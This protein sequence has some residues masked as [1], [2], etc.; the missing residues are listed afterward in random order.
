[1]AIITVLTFFFSVDPARDFDDWNQKLISFEVGGVFKPNGLNIWCY[2]AR[3][4]K[5]NL[6]TYCWYNLS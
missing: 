1:M 3:V 2:L 6:F 5:A 4:N